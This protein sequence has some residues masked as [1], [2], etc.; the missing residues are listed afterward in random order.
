MPIKRKKKHSHPLFNINEKTL[1]TQFFHQKLK[2]FFFLKKIKP[3]PT[4]KNN[5]PP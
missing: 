1:K 2:T 4:D 5:K 3:T